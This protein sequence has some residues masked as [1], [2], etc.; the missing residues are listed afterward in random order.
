MLKATSPAATITGS[1]ASS[2]G[3]AVGSFLLS[4]RNISAFDQIAAASMRFPS[5]FGGRVT[6]ASQVTAST[7]AE[8]AAKPVRRVT[9]TQTD[10]SPLKITALVVLTKELIDGPTPSGLNLL[11][12]ELRNS[13]ARGTDSAF[14]TALTG[15]S[16]S[17]LG[18]ADSW[19]GFL[20]TL[21]E[22]LRNLSLGSASRVFAIVSPAMARTPLE[23][24]GP[25]KAGTEYLKG[26]ATTH[27][28]GLWVALCATS[29]AKPG[30]SAEWMLAVKS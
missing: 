12:Q 19:Q 3:P 4:L 17:A 7:V 1:G 14:L 28:G 30:A 18:G 24:R 26:N 10:F 29:S 15:N 27:R 23:F 16:D 9:L 22:G 13:V 5:Q 20:D 6:V 21:K 11:I 2:F 25:W 8:G